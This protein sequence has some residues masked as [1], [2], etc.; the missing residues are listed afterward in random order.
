MK[1]VNFDHSYLNLNEQFYT[2]LK[3][4]NWENNSYV[5]VNEELA[6]EL[7][8]D[9]DFI[10]SEDGK[11]LF[12]GVEANN[13]FAQAYCG[14]QYGHFTNLGDGRALVL[15]EHLVDDTRYDIQLK[16][17][18]ITPYSRR[19]DGK[20]TLYSMLREFLVSE[21]MYKLNVPTTRSLAVLETGEE[22]NRELVHKGA[23]L[24]RTALS[25]I[26]VGTFEFAFAFDKQLVK[27]LA[28]YTMQRHYPELDVGDYECMFSS[29][30]TKQAKLIA[31]WQSIG[32]VHGV[33][34]TDNML[35][36]GETI[37]YGPCAFMNIYD[38][39]TVFSSIDK[40]GRYAYGKQP[41]IGSWN[42]A[43]LAETLLELFDG[44]QKKA[45]DI[46]N[47]SLKL[48][49]E[50]YNKEF[51]RLFSLKLG[52]NPEE[53]NL[54]MIEDLLNIMHKKLDFTN[55][56]YYLTSKQ[57]SK[58]ES[59]EGMDDWLA[60]WKEKTTFEGM[61]EVNPVVIPRNHLVEEA[62]NSAKD[63]DYHL[64]DELFFLLKEPYNYDK[65]VDE[66]YFQYSMEEY[67]TY[68]GT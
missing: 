29:I 22:V 2:K 64:F 65:E 23:I 14:H 43:R 35:V 63:G 7:K 67:I 6:D 11:K 13:A 62:L 41:Y 5:K 19:G 38:I 9:V 56:F 58:I 10:L 28:D 51:H 20:A 16:G 18:G 57:F 45:V 60:K 37:D 1:K 39:E 42:L 32:F 61:K 36:S 68:C 24:V 3:P 40:Q 31:K 47:K 55:T 21:A 4:T 54:E 27:E 30:V 44:D 66:K 34:N 33:M 8:I 46:A 50:T 49:E 15:G 17:S 53:D 52:L 12:S 59:V 48:Y 25:H 26:R